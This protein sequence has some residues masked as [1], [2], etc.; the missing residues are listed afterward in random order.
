MNAPRTANVDIVQDMMEAAGWEAQRDWRQHAA[1]GAEGEGG[2]V[3]GARDA[4]QGA[5]TPAEM[6]E[7]AE[8]FD[9]DAYDTALRRMRVRQ[10]VGNDGWRGVL[11][12]WADA[13]TR[14]AYLGA[15]RWMLVTR[16]FPAKWSEW[17]VTMIEKRNK[18]PSV[19]KN[20][21]D[22]WQS[23]HG[24]KIWTGMSRV[25]YQQAAEQAMPPYAVGFRAGRNA[26]EAVLTALLAGEQAAALAVPCV[27]AFIDLKGFFM[28]CSRAAAYCLELSV[29]VPTQIARGMWDL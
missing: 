3:G 23:C 26:M 1:E 9:E 12:R 25:R 4:R 19:F 2:E 14:T 10:A 28:G 7:A 27:R 17:I 11:M 6:A 13:W 8:I 5:P 29:G 24:W 18:D 22:I 16:R 15:L 20:L 21:R